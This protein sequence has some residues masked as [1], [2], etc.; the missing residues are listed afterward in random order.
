MFGKIV[1]PC[2]GAGF[3]LPGLAIAILPRWGRFY[4]LGYQ[5]AT[6]YYIGQK[7]GIVC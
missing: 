2:R 4:I 5:S 1:A 7:P 3:A 6:I